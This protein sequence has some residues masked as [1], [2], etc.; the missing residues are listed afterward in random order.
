MSKK[1]NGCLSF[2]TGGYCCLMGWF[3]RSGL[4]IGATTQGDGNFTATQT[5]QN[6]KPNQ[7]IAV[8]C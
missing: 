1:C 7:T 3:A 8:L 6:S 4:N 2:G 5:P